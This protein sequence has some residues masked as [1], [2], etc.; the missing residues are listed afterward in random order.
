VAEREREIENNIQ[1]LDV[2]AAAA[3]AAAVDS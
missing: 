2:E 1:E 3:V